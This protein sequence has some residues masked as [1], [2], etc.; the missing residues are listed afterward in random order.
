MQNEQRLSFM[1][2]I[3]VVMADVVREGIREHE[4]GM[5]VQAGATQSAQVAPQP[6]ERIPDPIVAKIADTIERF[7]TRGFAIGVVARIFG[8][9]EAQIAREVDEWEARLEGFVDSR[10]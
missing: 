6:E 9:P 5:H 7:G 8:Y 1:D 4:A 3:G 2:H 10:A